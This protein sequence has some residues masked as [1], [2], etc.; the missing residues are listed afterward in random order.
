M[1]IK[2]DVA[3]PFN[4]MLN[5]GTL[6]DAEGIEQLSSG[7]SGAAQTSE[8][9]SVAKAGAAFRLTLCKLIITIVLTVSALGLESLRG[10]FYYASAPYVFPIT[11]IFASIF[12]GL[13]WGILT[14]LCSCALITALLAPSDFLGPIGILV[15]F[16]HAAWLGWRAD[17]SSNLEIFSEG[18]KFWVWCG[19]P[20]LCIAALPYFQEFFWG[21]T[22]IVLQELCSNILT[23]LLFSLIFHSSR[24]RERL[25]SLAPTA[26]H[27][28]QHSIRYT[29]ELGVA[30]LIVIPATFFLIMEYV[31]RDDANNTEFLRLARNTSNLYNE[32]VMAR[33]EAVYLSTDQLIKNSENDF[34]VI[35]SKLSETLQSLPALCGYLLI[36]SSAKPVVFNKQCEGLDLS[37]IPMSLRHSE[38]TGDSLILAKPAELWTH[39][40]RSKNFELIVFLEQNTVNKTARLIAGV[41]DESDI[42]HEVTLNSRRIPWSTSSSF[43]I[44]GAPKANPHFFS[45]RLNEQVVH[46]FPAVV[47]S[48]WSATGVSASFGARLFAE[49]QLRDSGIFLSIMLSILLSLII[50]VRLWMRNELQGI[51]QLAVFLQR[52]SPKSDARYDLNRFEIAEFDLLRQSVAQLTENLN[53]LQKAQDES[54]I[55]L[56][57]RADQLKG[58]VEQSKAFLLLV[59]EKGE[60]ANHN[61]LSRSSEYR[62]IRESFIA[63]VATYSSKDSLT[64]KVQAD[65]VV[66]NTALAWLRSGES[67]FFQETSLA[68]GDEDDVRRLTLQFGYYGSPTTTYFARVE[69][70]SEFIIAKEQLAHTSRLAEL[71]ELATGVAHELGQPLNAITMS[72]SNITAKMN[73]GELD[74]SYL[75]AK[76]VRIQEQVVRSA[77][78]IDDLKS[79][80][81]AK[82]LV[83]EEVEI[84]TIIAASIQMVRSQFE[85][86]NVKVSASVSQGKTKVLVDAQQIEQVLINLFNN[87]KHVLAK[88]GGGELTV[89]QS[90]KGNNV[91]IIVRDNG[92]GIDDK[93]K[94]KIFTPFYTTK[95]SEGGT[96]LGLSISQ[97]IMQDHGGNLVLLPSSKGACFELLIPTAVVT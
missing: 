33:S 94:D 29:L 8:H 43:Q 84:S 59:N 61:Q 62:F 23:L 77:K 66:F 51:Q 26:C 90:L 32:W 97:K 95:I 80:A 38:E 24:L 79:F 31:I 69:D 49:S 65:D 92:P 72:S 50:F 39:R 68:F 5:V 96:G 27:G 56:K 22:T 47:N 83:R 35:A 87:A 6:S 44:T 11:Y 63:A 18:L 93:L 45:Q 67:R 57:T 14:S 30:S 37:G 60:V 52:Y 19:T 78:I 74:D 86:D 82:K 7:L 4:P 42:L 54:I 28:G 41:S 16:L 75:R 76:L 12:M 85:L 15:H 20:L 71:G 25:N 73:K 48:E 91:S 58:M 88:Q 21:G 36:T 40:I 10:D 46:E 13:R 9:P 53:T 55:E 1:A 70:I 81:R 89:T 17:K 34:D 3:K 64:D 2:D